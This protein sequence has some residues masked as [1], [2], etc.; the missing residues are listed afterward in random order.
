LL[1][2]PSADVVVASDHG[3]DLVALSQ[4]LLCALNQQGLI[5]EDHAGET[6]HI[7]FGTVEW[8]GWESCCIGAIM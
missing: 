6:A 8:V 7:P 1:R 5:S 2:G 3:N 4:Q